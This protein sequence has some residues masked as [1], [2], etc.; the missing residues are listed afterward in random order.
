MNIKR[1]AMSWIGRLAA[2]A[3]LVCSLALPAQAAIYTGVWDPTYGAPFPNLGW[4]G[5]AQ[6][7]VP[8]FCKSTTTADVDNQ[9]ECDGLAAFQSATV[10]FYD[11]TDPNLETI[12]SIGFDPLSLDIG[13]LRFVNG[14]LT[15]LTTT[16]SNFVLP[17]ADLTGFEV[18]RTTSF[19]LQFTLEGPRLA[20]GSCNVDTGC[21][22]NGFN[23]SANFPPT[24]VITEI[25]VP[26]PGTPALAVMA[27]L[28]LAA[29]SLHARR[30]RRGR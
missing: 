27:L 4:R 18:P 10:Q 5:S 8:D 16:L 2:A 23:D 7:F 22:V 9:A 24:F 25:T 14:A 29:F 26:E 28:L 11:T 20:N 17:D 13:T 21:T 3:G 15:Q 6:F 19:S 30:Q 1:L 12:I